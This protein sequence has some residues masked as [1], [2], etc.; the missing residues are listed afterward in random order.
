MSPP[1]ADQPRAVS[2]IPP[3]ADD[4]DWRVLGQALCECDRLDSVRIRVPASRARR[5]INRV[6]SETRYAIFAGV[7]STVHR[8]P[9]T[10]RRIIVR[11]D[12]TFVG[13]ATHKLAGRVE[14]WDLPALDR[15]LSKDRF[16]RLDAVTIEI[17]VARERD[18]E[19]IGRE[20]TKALPNLGAAGLLRI[21][22]LS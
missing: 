3:E 9:S 11:I 14:L 21:V 8:G 7:F 15:I 13:D 2:R 20:V 18:P 10:L 22:D 17:L 4:L 1:N 16:P 12:S 19:G 5:V 6:N